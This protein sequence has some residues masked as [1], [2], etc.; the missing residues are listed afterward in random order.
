[1]LK[2]N[3]DKDSKE[4]KDDFKDHIYACILA[5]GGGTRL[6]PKSTNKTPKQF[7]K[8]FGGKTLSQITSK[9]LRS[10]LTWDKIY[11]VTVSNDYKKELLKEVPLLH[12][13]NIIVEPARRNTAPAHTI[14][15][16]YILKKDPDAV[17]INAAA[18]HL[19]SPDS[20]Y[21]KTMY[22][23]TKVAYR[24]DH[25]VA[26]GIK[27]TYPGTGYGH[28]KR[29]K[30]F[31]VVNG[32][33]VYRSEKFVEKPDHATAER[34]NKTGKYFWNANHYVW[35]ADSLIKAIEKFEP[36]VGKAMGKIYNAIGTSKENAIVLK[37][38]KGLPKETTDGKSLSI[39]YA[40]SEKAKNFLLIVATYNWT[41]IGD[42]NEVWANLKHDSEG[43]VIID[44]GD[45]GGEVMQIDTTNAL[46]HT[47]GRLVVAID[48]DDV[49]VVDTKEVLLVCKKNQAQNVKKIV[50]KLKEDKRVELL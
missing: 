34:F 30:K 37:E 43:N 14:G 10:F 42:W 5:G 11:V 45:K 32:V 3:I 40:V 18:D 21:K 31:G 24:G 47:D 16:V 2:L 46:I 12:P 9:R 6:W 50:N 38:Y 49:V 25:L 13:D 7:L 22:A 44:G 27:P 4:K 1:M 26:V 15:A 17:I 41:D 29:G 8:L 35:R 36:K 33:T 23:A 48:V 20:E 28:L 19:I 39:D